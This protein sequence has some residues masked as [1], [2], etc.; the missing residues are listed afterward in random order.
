MADGVE[1]RDVALQ[2]LDPLVGV[3]EVVTVRDEASEV[4]VV[5]CMCL[6]KGC[7]GLEKVVADDLL[8]RFTGYDQP[9]Q[10]DPRS[11]A[12]PLG[13][14]DGAVADE[15]IA[16][17]D[18]E[19]F[20]IVGD[21][22]LQ[23]VAMD[24]AVAEGVILGLGLFLFQPREEADGSQDAVD[25]VGVEEVVTDQVART[26]GGAVVAF[27]PLHGVAEGA[28]AEEVDGRDEHRLPALVHEVGERK[29][30]RVRV[31]AVLAGDHRIGT[32]VGRGLHVGVAAEFRSA[33][34]HRLV[35]S[36]ELV[37]MVAHV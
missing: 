15:V 8:K 32:E 23:R 20:A 12:R 14:V 6:T 3:G 34:G 29:R 35:D 4:F 16:Y 5:P 22:L 9:R 27:G 28:R 31:V 1:R 13:G 21:A 7:V 36:A 33:L 30:V 19:R 24:G 18:V 26:V 17:E 10:V 25:E 37:G 2:V 11:T